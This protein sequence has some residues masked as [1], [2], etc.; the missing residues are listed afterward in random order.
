MKINYAIEDYKRLQAAAQE[1]GLTIPLVAPFSPSDVDQ[2]MPLLR[3]PLDEGSIQRARGT[4]IGRSYDSTGY[5]YQ[6]HVDRMNYVF[7]PTNWTWKVTNE[8]VEE[9]ATSNNRT[10]YVYSGDIELLIGYR[11]LNDQTNQ[12]DWITVHSVPPIPTDHESIE[13]G[14]ARKGMLSKGLKRS[15]SIL[16]VGADAYLGILD[17]DFV[18]GAEPGEHMQPRKKRQASR[19]KDDLVDQLDYEQLVSLGKIKGFKLETKLRSYYQA[20][21]E[22]R[23]ANDPANLTKAEAGEVVDMLHKLP[24][25][26]EPIKTFTRPSTFDELMVLEESDIRSLAAEYNIQLPADINEKNKAPL[27]KT[28]AHL[29]GIQ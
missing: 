1:F 26:V 7:G 22:G 17:D 15:T 4:D 5:S 23:I 13:K 8:V 27:C 11:R 3:M 28:I 6:A 16:G 12:W 24:D 21:T 19:L 2:L 18:S 29:M 10:K 14:S 20:Q 25:H 9:G